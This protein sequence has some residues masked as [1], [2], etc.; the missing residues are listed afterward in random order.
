MAK[1]LSEYKE[2][3]RKQMT[4]EKPK[5]K[6]PKEWILIIVQAESHEQK[7]LFRAAAKHLGTSMSEFMIRC[8]LGHMASLVDKGGKA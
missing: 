3:I 2:K 1:K 5:P 4:E 6:E 8:A 7:E